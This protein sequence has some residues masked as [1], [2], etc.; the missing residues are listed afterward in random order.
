MNILIDLGHPAH[1]H[2]YKNFYFE[3]K[4]RGHNI[5]VTVK[6]IPSAIRLLDAYGI[7][8]IVIGKKGKTKIG[9]FIKQIWFDLRTIWIVIR[10]RIDIG[11]GSSITTTHVSLVT[12][13]KSIIFD[14]DDD[15]VQPLFVKFAHPF[16]TELLSP[17]ALRGNR[18]R[19]DTIFYPAYHEIA[20]LHPSRFNPDPGILDRAGIKKGD[21]YF[22]LRFNQFLAHHDYNVDGLTLQQK[23]KLINVLLPHGRVFVTTESESDHVFDK[24]RIKIDSTEIHSF[25]YYAKL[26]LGDSQTMSSEASVLGTPSIRCNSLVGR[27]SS[28]NEQE[29]KY[30]LCF[31]FKP[32][33]LENMLSKIIELLANQN[34]REE[35]EVKRD[36]MLKDKFDLSGFMLWF[37]ENYP[38][39]KEYRNDRTI[40]KQ[41]EITE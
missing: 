19:V 4:E 26:F 35:W 7:K 23:E 8:Y 11:L 5:F 28:L 20:Y 17:D 33:D 27:I 21:P 2:L 38:A 16:A 15:D 13:M 6:E 9:K 24:Y 14:D 34:L 25:I 22:I 1:V 12:A 37:V 31:G 18:G 3:A 10:Y 40:F 36:N 41:K 32:E 30:G 29:K 39:S